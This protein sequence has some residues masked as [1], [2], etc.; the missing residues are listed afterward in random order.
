M[1]AF[2]VIK[3]VRKTYEIRLE[4]IVFMDMAKMVVVIN[5]RGGVGKDMFCDAIADC[6]NVM[7]VSSID[8]IKDIARMVGWENGKE[9]KDRKFLSDLK[10]LVVEYNDYPTQYLMQEHKR[11]LDDEV[12]QVMFV[13]I[14]EPKEIDKFK[15]LLDGRCVTLKIE[16]KSVDG[17]VYGNHSDDGV[18]AYDY[19]YIYHNDQPKEDALL[20]MVKF[21]NF[22][23][24]SE[25]QKAFPHAI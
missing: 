18:D 14:R 23:I 10:S 13:H 12:Y 7:N 25:R 15:N 21:F 20:D 1:I 24:D 5:G 9:L 17:M 22:M 6:F 3:F 8:P 16:R 19:D 11:F 2:V 4:E